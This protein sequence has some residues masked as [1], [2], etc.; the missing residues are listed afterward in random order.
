MA[1]ALAVV[2]VVASIAQLHD[3]GTTV[4][5]RLNKYQSSS[6]EVTESFHQI[7]M[8]L[9]LLLY[10]I[11]RIQEAIDAGSV[12]IEIKKA[13][14]P[15]IKICQEEVV[16]LLQSI[17]TETSSKSDDSSPEKGTKATILSAGQDGKIDFI[18]KN[19]EKYI[20]TLTFYYSAV[21]STL[22]PQQGSVS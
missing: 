7:K 4:L 19:I 8:E 13:L 16:A 3:F 22:Q 12:G 2:G 6:G 14:L 11:H 10:T 20:N 21:S 9:P 17:L 18:L 15:V 1:E 5:Y